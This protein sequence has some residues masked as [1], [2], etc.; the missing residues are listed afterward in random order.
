MIAG[1]AVAA[2]ERDRVSG[3]EGVPEWRALAGEAADI[4]AARHLAEA[5]AAA[6]GA[7]LVAVDLVRS[8]QGPIVIDISANLPIAQI[9][10]LTD[11]AIAEAVIIAVEQEV[12]GRA[13]RAGSPT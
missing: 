7:G 8:R 2:I 9:E 12:R 3:L 6:V 13:A 1:R 4:E 10:R 11:A 5:S